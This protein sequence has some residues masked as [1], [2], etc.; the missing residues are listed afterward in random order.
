[1]DRSELLQKIKEAFQV[2]LNDNNALP[3]YKGL[4]DMLEAMI[5]VLDV[6]PGD[7]D[8]SAL[9]EQLQEL[10]AKVDQLEPGVPEAGVEEMIKQAVNAIEKKLGDLRSKDETQDEK[11]GQLR[12]DVDQL[13][14]AKEWQNLENLLGQARDRL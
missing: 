13:P 1:M 9:Q 6:S 4:P 14:S 12:G 8:L 5:A 3:D 10:K 7:K 2:Y 11:I